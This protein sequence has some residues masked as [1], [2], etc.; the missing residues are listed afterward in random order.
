MIDVCQYAVN[1][2]E[3]SGAD[4]IEAVWIKDISTRIEAELGEISKASMIRNEGMRIRV[5]KDNA[6]SSVFTYH[7]DKDSLKEVVGK[8]LAAARASKKDE[9]WGSLPSPQ[10]Y[11]HVKAWDSAMA[12]AG[13][14]DLMEPITEMLQLLPEDIVAFL[15]LNQ[16][17]LQEKACVN[18]NGIEHEDKGTLEV[19]G[20]A[21][22]GKLDDGVTP[23]FQKVSFLRE[24]K[25]DPQ[26]IAE[27]LTEEV[28]LFRKMET[29]SPGK[30]SVVLSP[31]ALE[32]LLHFTLFKAVSGENVARGKSLLAGREGEK[33][34]S[35]QLTLHDTGIIPHGT[36]SREMDDEG[37]PCQ[38]TCVIEEGIL[39]GFIWNDYWAKRTAASSTG[40]AYY[41]DQTDELTIRESTMVV[42]PG[43]YT[44]EELLNV[45]DGYY[46]LDFQGAHGSNPES[47]DFS[48]LCTPAY[49][50]RN[51]E[52]TGGVVGM[53][54][55]D[56]VFSLLQKIDAVGRDPEIG[57]ISILPCIRFADVNVAAK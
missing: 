19:I 49:R 36:A 24:F 17:F 50:I 37:V 20:M 5:I 2:G 16:I 15:A 48:V 55:S 30:S 46:V 44:R 33:V 11:P 29:A 28:T 14:K 13:S 1:I 26:R 34:A 56:N 4:E 43:D 12:D 35:S 31:Q 54:L 40:N 7:M 42:T 10:D 32:S 41:N 18:S 3:R 57:E 9:H 51:G 38:D 53:M 45:K 22:I 23:A 6:I 52:I 8:A 25:P 21:V 27:S 39:R 47:G